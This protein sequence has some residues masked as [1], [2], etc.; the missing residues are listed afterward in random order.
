MRK[1]IKSL[2]LFLL[3]FYI[4]VHKTNAQLS[5]YV[6]PWISY[7]SIQPK[8]LNNTINST[9]YMHSQRAATVPGY[10]YKGKLPEIGAGFDYG[11]EIVFILND[12]LEAGLGFDFITREEK[13]SIQID[14]NGT[15]EEKFRQQISTLPIKLNMYFNFFKPRFSNIKMKLYLTGG[16]DYHFSNCELSYESIAGTNT[17]INEKNVDIKADDYGLGFHFGIG[18]NIKVKSNIYLFL[19]LSYMYYKPSD[20][21]GDYRII[22]QDPYNF[23]KIA[24]PLV[25]YKEQCGDDLISRI[26]MFFYVPTDNEEYIN[27]RKAV[28][29]FSHLAIKLGIKLGL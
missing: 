28:I 12:L 17:D 6:K 3:F 1:Y 29:D 19:E 18:N 24:G 16:L 20:W 5:L 25:Y 7:S 8:D 15:Y 14:N 11:G 21:E 23:L 22:E 4:G 27:P 26:N 9:N 13:A 2:L 10:S